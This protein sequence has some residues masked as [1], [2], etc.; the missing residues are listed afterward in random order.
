M[1]VLFLDIDGV[2]N[3]RADW[4]KP[5]HQDKGTYVVDQKK[6]GCLLAVVKELGLSVVLSSS[7]RNHQDHVD[8]LYE[9]GVLSSAWVHDDWRTI[10]GEGKR[11]GNSLLWS[12]SLR[13][14]EIQEWLD[15]HPEVTAY[16][17]VDD[18]EEFLKHQKRYVIR[19]SFDAANGGFTAR[20]ARKVREIFLA[21]LPP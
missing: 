7:W 8:Y 9:Q 20:H 18:A 12:P 19:T 1:R 6:V 15:R 16:V 14:E 21:N 3:C 11:I 4:G 17:I 5:E 2:L 10:R 13:G